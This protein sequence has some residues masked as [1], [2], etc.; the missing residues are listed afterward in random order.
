MRILVVHPQQATGRTLVA[1]LQPQWDAT[2]VL[3]AETGERGLRLFRHQR[4]DVVLLATSLADRP[5]LEMLRDIRRVSETPVLLLGCSG[6]DLEQVEGLRLGA[7]DYVVQPVST[8]VL[9][10][11]IEAVQRRASLA[12]PPGRPPDFHCG[13]LAIWYRRRLATIHAAPLNLT[14]LEY[15]L[16]LQLVL[17][18]Y[19]IVPSAVLLEAVWGDAYGATTKYLK[20]FINRLRAKL[21]HDQGVP[22]IETQRRVGYRLVAPEVLGISH[23]V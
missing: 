13:A 21:G 7:D 18:A 8:R 22:S 5:A 20:V 19:D 14:P 12:S 17:H 2:E 23:I 10:A 9:A 1:E 16:L 15:Q 4:P 3:S 11:R 6:A